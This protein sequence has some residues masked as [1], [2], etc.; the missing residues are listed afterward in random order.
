MGIYK[1]NKGEVIY[2]AKNILSL[3][4][5]E[6]R[7][8]KRNIQMIFQDPY[9]SLDPLMNIERLLTEPLDVHLKISKAEKK[10]KVLE[11][12]EKVGLSKRH[13]NRYPYEFSGGQRQRIAIARALVI[14]PE[15]VVADE[16]VSALDISIQAQ[17]LNLLLALQ[18]DMKLTCLVIAHDLNVIYH[19]CDRVAV[20]YLGKIVELSSIKSI[21]NNPLHP[22]TQALMSAIPIPDPRIKPKGIVLSGEVPSPLNPPE[23][24]RF[25]TR[26]P[27]KQSKCLEEEPQFREV[28]N[29]HFVSCHFYKEIKDMKEI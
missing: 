7:K 19:I 27:F 12:L 26:C 8:H 25:N 6:M 3:K 11:M 4:K 21:F 17:I 18:R 13:V 23:G 20:M 24:C 5:G 2:K 10:R 15:F 16:P 9:S 1:P 29:N 14:N 22:Y 28:E